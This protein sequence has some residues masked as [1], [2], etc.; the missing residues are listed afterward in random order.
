MAAPT[1]LVKIRV[2]NRPRYFD[3][4][5]QPVGTV[6]DMPA[7]LAKEWIYNRWGETVKEAESGEQRAAKEAESVKTAKQAESE[8]KSGRTG[9]TR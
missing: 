2:I 7:T 6:L 3:R 5:P 4:V 1:P 9:R 8:E